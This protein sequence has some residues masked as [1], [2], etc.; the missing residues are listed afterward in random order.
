MFDFLKKETHPE[1]EPVL[2]RMRMNAENNYRDATLS[3]LAE[4]KEHFSELSE[5]GRL[6]DKQKAYYSGL[7]SRYTTEFKGFTHKEQKTRW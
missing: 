4:L 7:I 6:N 1:L 5:Q 2:Q 3:D